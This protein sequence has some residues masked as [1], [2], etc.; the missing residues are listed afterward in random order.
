MGRRRHGL[1]FIRRALRDSLRRT[2]AR[3]GVEAQ[4]DAGLR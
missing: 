1:I 2:V 3:F 4:E